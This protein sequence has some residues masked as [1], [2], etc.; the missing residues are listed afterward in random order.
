MAL[1]KKTYL[2]RLEVEFE[3]GAVK[4]VFTEYRTEIAESGFIVSATTHRTPLDKEDPAVTA[5]I[6]EANAAALKAV[7]LAQA[8]AEAL[9]QRVAQ[10]EAHHA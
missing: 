8:E 6:G 3:E 4:R 10:L 7:T 5:A 9:R 2:R 1:E